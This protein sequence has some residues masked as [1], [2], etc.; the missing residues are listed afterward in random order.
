MSEQSNSN[1]TETTSVNDSA[2]PKGY[3][4]KSVAV[5][6]LGLSGALVWGLGIIPSIMALAKAKKASKEVNAS[7]GKFRGVGLIKWG[8]ALAITGILNFIA[9]VALIFGAVWAIN[10][11]PIWIE[12]AITDGNIA[13]IDIVDTLPPVNLTELGIP[14]DSLRTIE[15]YLPSGQSLESVNLSD[16]L[17][18]AEAEGINVSDYLGSLD[19]D[20][21]LSSSQSQEILDQLE[22][23]G[24]ASSDIESLLPNGETLDT[25]QL[26]TLIDVIANQEGSLAGLSV[27]DLE[28]LGLDGF[29]LEGLLQPTK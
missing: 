13:G 26:G 19:P 10:Q 23:Q 12:D 24:Y 7:S 20:G 9:G 2:E 1:D 25:V 29:G 18:I 14:E 21:T 11:I 17:D 3:A 6:G 16:L 4:P 27:E 15:E 8:I 22:Q 28:D 5:F